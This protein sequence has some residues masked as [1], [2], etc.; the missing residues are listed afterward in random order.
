ME[1]TKGLIID[2]RHNNG[3]LSENIRIIVSRF[4]HATLA[5]PRAFTKGEVPYYKDPIQ[6]DMNHFKDVR[7]N[8]LDISEIK[9][10]ASNGNLTLNWASY[11]I[12]RPKNFIV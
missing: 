4:I 1:H 12:S 7:L 3:G 8:K 9:A 11:F 6:P 2:V 5:W 10:I